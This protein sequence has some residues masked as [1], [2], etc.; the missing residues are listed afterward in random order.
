MNAGDGAGE[1]PSQALLDMYIKLSAQT[2]P[3]SVTI[4]K[5]IGHLEGITVTMV[6][7]LLYGRTVHSLARLLTFFNVCF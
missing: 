6:G 3:S 1:H 5:E 4:N 7:D 2:I